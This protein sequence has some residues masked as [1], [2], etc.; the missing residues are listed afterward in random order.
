MR[1][2]W[3]WRKRVDLSTLDTH[4]PRLPDGES[5]LCRGQARPYSE[6]LADPNARTAS[7]PT[8]KPGTPVGRS[9]GELRQRGPQAGHGAVAAEDL[10][11]LEQGK[12]DGASGDRH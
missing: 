5:I 11:R 2:R 12:P 8:V 7:F 1:L 3:P 6:I 10:Q 9:G 4:P